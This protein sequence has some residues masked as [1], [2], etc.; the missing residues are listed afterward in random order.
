MQRLWLV[1][2]S[3]QL[4]HVELA[5]PALIKAAE[6]AR[7]VVL[8]RGAEPRQRVEAFTHPYAFTVAN[9]AH[10]RRTKLR[11]TPPSEL[12]RGSHCTGDG[13]LVSFQNPIPI[14]HTVVP[15]TP[16]PSSHT[17]HQRMGNT[18][19]VIGGELRQLTSVVTRAEVVDGDVLRRHDALVATPRCRAKPLGTPLNL[20]ALGVAASACNTCLVD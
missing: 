14:Q 11:G 10:R 8:G 17:P 15:I 4:L 7:E 3:V 1:A 5:L 12:A 20:T 13:P 16:L 6:L 9:I 19:L 2:S 18:H